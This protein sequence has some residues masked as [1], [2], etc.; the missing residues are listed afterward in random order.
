MASSEFKRKRMTANFISTDLM[1][2]DEGDWKK[3]KEE[4]KGNLK[5]DRRNDIYCL[6]PT[7]DFSMYL[8]YL[9]YLKANYRDWINFGYFDIGMVPYIMWPS[10]MQDTEAIELMKEF[11]RRAGVTIVQMRGT[12][13]LKSTYPVNGGD[14]WIFRED[15]V[16]LSRFVEKLTGVPIPITTPDNAI[17]T[18]FIE[19][20]V[21]VE[22]KLRGVV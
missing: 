15:M 17:L 11:A 20:M 4:H 9:N 6:N 14:Y 16:A 5:H 3:F 8:N 21:T 12:S 19:S 7:Y 18:T 2:Y 1:F 13:L 10:F 22:R